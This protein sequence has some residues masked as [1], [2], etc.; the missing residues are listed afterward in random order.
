M[1]GVPIATLK[2]KLS[3]HLR[4]VRRGR[5]VTVLDRGTPIARIM[6]YGS[7][8]ALAVRHA[9]RKPGDLPVPPPAQLTTDSL[10]ILLRDR[11]KR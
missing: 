4:Q 1:K 11:A 3:E 10:S 6:P 7:S 5:I 2:A 9:T 8:E